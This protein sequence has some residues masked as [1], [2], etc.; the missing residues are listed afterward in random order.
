M[1][2]TQAL[3]RVQKGQ[4]GAQ[5]FFTL[6][7]RAFCLYS[8]LGDQRDA[9]GLVPTVNDVTARITVAPEAAR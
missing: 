5:R 6:N 4:A 2:S 7:G 9:R 1:Y 3:Q 8:V